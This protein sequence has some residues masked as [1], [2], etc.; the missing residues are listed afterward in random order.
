MITHPSLNSNHHQM[1][2]EK[3]PLFVKKGKKKKKTKSFQANLRSKV[4]PSEIIPNHPKCLTLTQQQQ[5]DLLDS[6]FQ[7]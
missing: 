3:G 2:T 5:F 6:I 1:N 7:L 4:Q